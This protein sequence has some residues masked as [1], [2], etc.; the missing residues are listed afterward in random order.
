ND[1][2]RLDTLATALLR[3]GRLPEARA[4]FTRT[5]AANPDDAAACAA[6]GKLALWADKLPLAESLLVKAGDVEQARADLYSTRIRRGEWAEA[7]EMS[8]ALGDDGRKPLL[9]H[10]AQGPGMEVTGEK[11]QLL[12]ERIWPAPLI[13]VKLSGS[14]VVM[15]LDT[16]TPGLLLDAS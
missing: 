16:G 12:F 11:A 9:E 1:L 15:M 4:L 13:E 5:L 14:Q 2:A 3:L 8:E 10:L 6:L 7:A